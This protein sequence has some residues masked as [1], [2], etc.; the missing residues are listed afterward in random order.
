MKAVV[1][2]G[3]QGRR[4][5]PY[6]TILPK[7]LMPVGDVPILEIVIRQL[8]HA[9]FDDITLVT[10]ANSVYAYVTHAR[11]ILWAQPVHLA[12]STG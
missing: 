9:G 3:G 5:A 1:L 4:L 8:K 12:C 7:P 2:A 10:A 11:N 6:T